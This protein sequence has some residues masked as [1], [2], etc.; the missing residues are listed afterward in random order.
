MNQID[1]LK[2]IAFVC[3][4]VTASASLAGCGSKAGTGDK[5]IVPVQTQAGEQQQ[6]NGSAETPQSNYDVLLDERSEKEQYSYS[7]DDL[8]FVDTVSGKKVS[9]GMSEQEVEAAA[10]APKQIDREYRIYNGLVVQFQDDKAVSL[11]VASGQFTDEAE[12]HRYKTTRGVGLDTSFDDFSKAYGDQYNASQPGNEEQQATPGS[13]IRYFKKDGSKI[14]FLG[15]TLSA[16]QEKDTENLYIQD[17]LTDRT[18]NQII[19][20]RVGLLSQ[21]TGGSKNQ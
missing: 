8:S 9:V 12:A 10:G 19:T 18:T 17:F 7:M 2:T 6:G 13:A 16:E 20:M 3:A 14:E 21:I 11:I 5:N 4:V 1:K 15:T